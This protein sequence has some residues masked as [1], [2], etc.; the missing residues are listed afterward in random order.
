MAAVPE[1][2]RNAR[3]TPERL[4]K[5]SLLSQQ[6]EVSAVVFQL[7]GHFLVSLNVPFCERSNSIYFSIFGEPHH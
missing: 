1:D 5:I 4:V 2:L 3:S 7:D 6:G